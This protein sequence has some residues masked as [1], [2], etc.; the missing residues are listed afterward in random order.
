M[1]P[2]YYTKAPAYFNTK[3]VKYYTEPHK[4]Y[5]TLY[6]TTTEATKYYVVQT[7]ITAAAPSY[8]VELK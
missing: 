4:Y 2:K 1:L 5:S 6:T 8:C 7:Y 3:A